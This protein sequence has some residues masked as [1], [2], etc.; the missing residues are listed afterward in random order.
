MAEV[1]ELGYVFGKAAIGPP[2]PLK[3]QKKISKV[4]YKG[5]VVR[6]IPE[7]E[8]INFAKEDIEHLD[9]V[10]ELGRLYVPFWN[11]NRELILGKIEALKFIPT[12]YQRFKRTYDEIQEYAQRVQAEK[13]NELFD[14]SELSRMITNFL[15]TEMAKFSLRNTAK[16]PN[17]NEDLLKSCFD[18]EKIREMFGSDTV[19]TG[20]KIEKAKAYCKLYQRQYRDEREEAI[21]KARKAGL[22]IPE[23]DKQNPC[24]SKCDN[25][26]FI[27]RREQVFGFNKPW[28][29]GE[30][31]IDPKYTSVEQMTFLPFGNISDPL[32]KKC[33][34]VFPTTMKEIGI[35][36]FAYFE[37]LKAI[38]FSSVSQL[39][40]IGR[41]AFQNTGI[42]EVDLSNI[43]IDRIEEG[44]FER[45]E[46]LKT[47]VFPKGLLG[48][49][50]GAFRLCPALVKVD[51]GRTRVNF[52]G[53]EAFYVCENLLELI[54]P[55]TEM[56]IE[57]R[58]FLN[59]SKLS[60]IEVFKMNK[61][62]IGYDVKLGPDSFKNCKLE[63]WPSHLTS[64][65]EEAGAKLEEIEDWQW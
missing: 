9:R 50:K 33:S 34:I 58:A 60:T 46:N 40:Y 16:G 65:L 5:Y 44:V 25:Q 61:N 47:V 32:P 51:L 21:D 28:R 29:N 45:C 20:T 8:K 62:D 56:Q 41:Q 31:I 1:N 43:K 30:Y 12:V 53:E 57:K 36:A 18:D 48:I 22:S 10:M 7:Q 4:T 15:P 37:G 6:E 14:N 52:I 27:Y 39:N 17:Q 19:E 11:E 38:T 59:C 2:P 24:L 26:A 35:Y 55:Q 63:T 13:F 49:D 42:A 23:T 54:L 64:A 3:E